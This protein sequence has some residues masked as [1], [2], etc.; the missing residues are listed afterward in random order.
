MI[1]VED[2]VS[3]FETRCRGVVVVPFDE[4]LA[5]GVEVDLDMMRP[6]VREA[7]FRLSALVAEGIVRH[8]RSRTLG[9][10]G[11]PQPHVAPPLPG[12]GEVS[13]VAGSP[14][15]ESR[16]YETGYMNVM[17]YPNAVE[18][19]RTDQIRSDRDAG[20]GGRRF[21][22]TPPVRPPTVRARR[23]SSSASSRASSSLRVLGRS[24]RSRQARKCTASPKGAGLRVSGQEQGVTPLARRASPV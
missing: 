5:A 3:H 21:R 6:K 7:Y 9:G 17:A 4:H 19:Y 20:A 14:A 11:N 8:Q 2:I 13:F 24:S 10:H 22:P 15:L 16:L 1:K 23:A 12:Q 18:A